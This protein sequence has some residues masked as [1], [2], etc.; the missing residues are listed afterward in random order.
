[1]FQYLVILY[2]HCTVDG[3]NSSP[4]VINSGVLQGSGLSRTLFRLFIN[5]SN[6]LLLSTHMF[7]T[8]SFTQ[9][10]HQPTE[11]ELTEARDES[12]AGLTS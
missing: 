11:Q 4:T 7:M 9:V 2:Q 6:L 1:M 10:N 8:P 12:Q 5:D 3:Y